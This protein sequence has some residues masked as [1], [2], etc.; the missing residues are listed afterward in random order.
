MG[1]YGAV[2]VGQPSN[3]IGASNDADYRPSDTGFTS[4]DH[5]LIGNSGDASGFLASDL[6]DVDPQLGPLQ[7]NGGPTQTM[8]LLAGSAAVNAGDNS[9]A[10]AYDQRGAGFPRIV[11]GTIDIGAFESDNGPDYTGL[12]IS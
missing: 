5:N 11:G 7:N 3:S 9:S 12:R 4:L 1:Y 2:A 10:P 8:A 6:L